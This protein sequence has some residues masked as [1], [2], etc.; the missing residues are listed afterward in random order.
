MSDSTE[1]V[2]LGAPDWVEEAQAAED[3][4]A[5]ESAARYDP[6][7]APPFDPATGEVLEPVTMGMDGPTVGHVVSVDPHVDGVTATVMITD[8]DTAA[9]IAPPLGGL[10]VGFDPPP[11]TLVDLLPARLADDTSQAVALPGRGE[12][13]AFA[14][15]LRAALDDRVNALYGAALAARPDGPVTEATVGPELAVLASV[16]DLGRI[17]AD[18]FGRMDKGA[19]A[20]ASDVVLEVKRPDPSRSLEHT[21]GSA[22]VRVGV[23][24][25]EDVKVTV[26]QPTE[27]FTDT[28]GIVDV[29]VAYHVSRIP[30]ALGAQPAVVG[31]YA[32]GARDMAQLLLGLDGVPSLLA[33]PKWKS[34]AL[35]ALRRDLERST[36]PGLAGRLDAAYGRRPVGNLQTTVERVEPSKRGK[37]RTIDGPA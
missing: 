17:M 4:W 33:S 31:A 14:G 13:A 12:L 23:R 34:S 15:N 26:T 11:T 1:W 3:A 6:F 16:S 37:P 35:D 7:D 36:E 25:G 8:A 22:S 20:L 28:P 27:T 5:E 2:D 19:R 24:A 21:G 29:V 32:E 30:T 9:R 18:V 10:S